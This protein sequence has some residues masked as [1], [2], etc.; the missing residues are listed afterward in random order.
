[1]GFA[2]ES[3]EVQKRITDTLQLM[4]TL[5]SW[6]DE[7]LRLSPETLIKVMKLGARIQKLMRGGTAQRD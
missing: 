4:E 5:G 3:R 7:M 1:P 2:K 6:G